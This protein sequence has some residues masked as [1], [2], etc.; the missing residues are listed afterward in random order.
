[1]EPL[2]D[3]VDDSKGI[4]IKGDTNNELDNNEDP[5]LTE[6]K[7]RVVAKDARLYAQMIKANSSVEG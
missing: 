5:I 2:E 1:L 4:G 3:D 6:I 7:A